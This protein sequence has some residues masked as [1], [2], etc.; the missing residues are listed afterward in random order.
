MSDNGAN[1]VSWRPDSA[2]VDSLN[3]PAFVVDATGVMTY[4]NPALVA[5]LRERAG[6]DGPVLGQS[7]GED[8]GAVREVLAKVLAGETWTGDLA[9]GL[10]TGPGQATSAAWTPVHDA[11][12]GRRGVGGPGPGSGRSSGARCWRRA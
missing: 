1:A 9:L 6:D 7:V 10:S 8:R 11:D 12:R 3:L 4:A 5:L 2:L